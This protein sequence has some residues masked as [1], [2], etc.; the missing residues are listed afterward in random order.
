[1]WSCLKNG[2]IKKKYD[3]GKPINLP[4]ENLY[5]KQHQRHLK[6]IDIQ[7]LTLLATDSNCGVK[8]IIVRVI[9]NNNDDDGK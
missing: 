6:N 9:L 2:T 3:R 1:M 8:E 7:S 5:S 4:A